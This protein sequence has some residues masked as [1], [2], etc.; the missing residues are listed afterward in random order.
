MKL[1][2]VENALVADAKADAEL[3]VAAA[4]RDADAKV[5]AA[6]DE[7]ARLVASAR[8]AGEREAG[9]IL[10]RQRS[11]TRREARSIVLDAQRTVFDE[12]RHRARAAVRALADEADYERFIAA[13]GGP[14]AAELGPNAVITVAPSGE[15]GIFAI[16]GS[17]R[18]DYRLATLADRAVDELGSQIASLWT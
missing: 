1:E 12:L 8:A 11:A 10:A 13:L 7:A 15:P 9:Q 2:A 16:D 6:R 14:A 4:D 18:V 17:R 3:L 5:Q